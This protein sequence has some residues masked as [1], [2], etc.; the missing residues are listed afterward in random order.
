MNLCNVIHR[1]V[2]VQSRRVCPLLTGGGFFIASTEPR[3]LSARFPIDPTAVV[4]G[5]EE[6]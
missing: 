1:A 4:A 3:G 6:K 2:K 5:I